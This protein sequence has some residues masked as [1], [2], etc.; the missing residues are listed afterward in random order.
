[1]AVVKTQYE[2]LLRLA[3]FLEKLPPK[4]FDFGSWVGVDWKDKP[5]LSCGTT[6][7]ALGWATVALPECGLELRRNGGPT[8]YA[9]V[10]L[11]S[12]PADV[13]HISYQD[14]V[15]A[16]KS[17]LGLTPKETELLFTPAEVAYDEDDEVI[18]DD[19]GRLP[20]GSSAAEVAAHIR[21]FVRN[22]QK[23]EAR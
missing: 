6:A 14:T 11:S 15:D 23:W 18:D 10:V 17:A 3:E 9:Y 4:R 5:D 21:L 7:C 20:D 13:E 2:R 22:K 12:L 1:M 19:D 8:G 16:A